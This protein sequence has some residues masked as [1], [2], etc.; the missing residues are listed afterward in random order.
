[1]VK[2][3]T[4]LKRQLSAKKEVISNDLGKYPKRE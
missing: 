1:M 3:L 4:S 2:V